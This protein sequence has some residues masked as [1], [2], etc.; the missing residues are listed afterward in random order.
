MITPV[1]TWIVK[2]VMFPFTLKLFSDCLVLGLQRRGTKLCRLVLPS[3]LLVCSF[4]LNSLRDRSFSLKHTDARKEE[5]SSSLEQLISAGK[6]S[7]KELE[8]LHGRL[9]WFSAFIFGR[10]INQ[11]V[12]QVSLL[13]RK[14]DRTIILDDAFLTVLREVKITINSSKPVFISRNLCKIW[15]VFTDGAYE[16]GT[17]PI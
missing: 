17:E 10:M 6:G 11:L 4:D 7:P 15:F 16:P 8:R 9:I 1:F 3:D 5:L 14:K 2:N 12:K 13:S